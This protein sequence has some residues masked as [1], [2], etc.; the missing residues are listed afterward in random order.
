MVEPLVQPI[1]L[2]LDTCTFVWLVA[3]PDRLSARAKA[4]IDAE[5]AELYISDASILEIC[6]KWQVSK[7]RLPAPPRHWVEVQRRQWNVERLALEPDHYYRITELPALHKDPFD[8]LLVA[9][10]IQ[11]GFPLVTPDPTIRAYP[12]ATIW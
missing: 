3:D 2:L 1:A 7:I 4:A 5:G 11:R 8:R 9:Q 6:L 12:V 10:G